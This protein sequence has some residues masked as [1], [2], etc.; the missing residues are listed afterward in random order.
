MARRNRSRSVRRRRSQR[1]G[2]WFTTMLGIKP[3]EPAAAAVPEQMAKAL[4][5]PVAVIPSKKYRIATHEAVALLQLYNKTDNISYDQ[6]VTLKEA[7]DGELPHG[8][9]ELLKKYRVYTSSNGT[10]IM[11]PNMLIDNGSVKEVTP[12]MGGRRSTRKQRR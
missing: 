8:Y 7:S 6:I 11:I 9:S 3:A 12:L 1:G 10:N 5:L 4:P 2:N